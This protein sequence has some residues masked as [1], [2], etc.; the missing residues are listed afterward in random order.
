MAVEFQHARQTDVEQDALDIASPL[1]EVHFSGIE[2]CRVLACVHQTAD[3]DA[4]ALVIFDDGDD[5][6]SGGCADLRARSEPL[7]I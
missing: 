4:E 6:G 7:T 5:H 2:S 1:N 3:R